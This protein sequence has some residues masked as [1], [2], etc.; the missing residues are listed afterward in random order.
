MHSRDVV[1]VGG[2]SLIVGAAA[3]VAVFS[4]LAA[5]FDYPKVLEGSAAEVLPQLRAGGSRMRAVWAVYSLLPLFLVVGAVGVFFALPARPGL[6]GLGAVF[7]TIGSLAMCLGLMRWPSIHWVLAET[8]QSGSAEA[9]HSIAAMFSGLN[10][11]LGNYIGEFLG[12]VCLGVFFLATAIALRS[13]PHYPAW[14]GIAGTVFSVLFLVGALRNAAPQVQRLADINNYLLPLW[15]V[16]LGGAI[17][18]FPRV[19]SPN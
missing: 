3:F 7:A 12:E 4:Y 9:K 14:L 15:L 8:H 2:W 10:L 16:V 5:F 19:Q 11:Y 17:I 1:L 18:W 13:E 6:A